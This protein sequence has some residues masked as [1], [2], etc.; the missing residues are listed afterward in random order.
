M[1]CNE[2]TTQTAKTM[3]EIYKL[4]NSVETMQ[5]RIRPLNAILYN[6]N[7][8]LACFSKNLKPAKK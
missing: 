1:Q 6:K 7:T 3:L 5:A 8:S 2:L 4:N